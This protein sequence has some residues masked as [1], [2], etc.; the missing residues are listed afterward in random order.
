[1]KKFIRTIFIN[2]IVLAFTTYIFP[3]LTYGGDLKA[4]TLAS[5]GFT[6]INFYLKPIVK[7]FLLPINLLTLGMLRWLTGVICLFVL[8]VVLPQIQ[9]KSF[10]FEGFS[11][12]GFVLPPF[13]FTPL[14]SLVLASLIISLTTSFILW[15]F[16]R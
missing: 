8:T 4:L 13:F 3:G 11:F 6:I 16:K 9:V 1:M 15:L 2:A 5:F 10:Q 12:G 7:L 14:I